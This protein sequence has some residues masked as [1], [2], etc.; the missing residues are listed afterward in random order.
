MY[1][2]H[3]FI[4]YQSRGVTVWDEIE[5]A[6]NRVVHATKR[7]ID[8]DVLGLAASITAT[9]GGAATV[10]TFDNVISAISAFRA[11]AKEAAGSAILM[12][13]DGMRDFIQDLAGSVLV[14]SERGAGAVA[15]L[16]ANGMQGPKRLD[17]LGMPA[18]ESDRMPVGD[19]TGWTNAIVELGANAPLCLAFRRNASLDGVA[20]LGDGGVPIHVEMLKSDTSPG[21]YIRA[22]SHHG[23]GISEQARAVNFITRT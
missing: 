20:M 23:V 1:M 4:G 14:T 7:K 6:V 22:W 9:Q 5:V 8:T 15:N 12:H 16:T 21:H 10:N 2:Q 17:V 13:T 19:T 3:V 18:I 11:S